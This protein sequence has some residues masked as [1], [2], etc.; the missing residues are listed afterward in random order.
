MSKIR[1]L[2]LSAALLAA[3]GAVASAAVPISASAVDVTLT[4]E[5]TR[6]L[7]SD[8]IFAQYYDGT[9]YQ[10]A[11]FTFY[12]YGYISQ[13]NSW[14]SQ[15]YNPNGKNVVIY[16]LD[17]ATSEI[18]NANNSS[19]WVNIFSCSPRPIFDIQNINRFTMSAGLSVAQESTDYYGIRFPNASAVQNS[20]FC[21]YSDYR[22]TDTDPVIVTEYLKYY[23]DYG[24]LYGNEARITL[25]TSEDSFLS[26]LYYININN[27]NKAFT[28]ISNHVS[29]AGITQYGRVGVPGGLLNGTQTNTRVFLFLECPTMTSDYIAANPPSWD[30]DGGDDSS[31]GGGYDGPDYTD[32]LALILAKLDLIVNNDFNIDVD[33]TAD[34]A[35]L[36]SRLDGVNSRLDGVNSRLDGNN[37]RMDGNNSRLDGVNSRLDGV[38][39]RLDNI[40]GELHDINSA[41]SGTLPRTGAENSE[42]DKQAEMYLSDIQNEYA[43]P[44]NLPFEVA[45]GSAGFLSFVRD[46]LVRSHLAGVLPV[47][48]LLFI[49]HYTI[50]DR[51][52]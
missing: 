23:N 21:V 47:L 11:F 51:R 5:Q 37:S 26:S 12:D 8:Q 22:Q 30:S 34:L 39:S 42:F 29:D 32:Q 52:G 36:E 33:L 43:D 10:D 38:N 45:E 50:F 9:D 3:A 13:V 15:S 48:A 2:Y 1:S 40:S 41:P 49:V 25:N 46:F 17:S 35:G 18:V 44:E 19:S 28:V 31:S 7:F 20:K 24:M 4:P 16:A 27:P 14:V 6:A